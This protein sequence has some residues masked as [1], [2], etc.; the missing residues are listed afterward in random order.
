MEAS[1]VNGLTQLLL[2]YVT[3]VNG[4]RMQQQWMNW[5]YYYQR[6]QQQWMNWRTARAN[7]LAQLLSLD[8]AHSNRELVGI[9]IFTST[10]TVIGLI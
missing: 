5:Q 4:H 9:I 1:T 2:P 8:S 3:T 10:A 6:V 7:G